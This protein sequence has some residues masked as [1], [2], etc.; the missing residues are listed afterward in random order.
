MGL[1]AALIGGITGTSLH[2]FANAT[3]KVPLS[4]RKYSYPHEALALAT[5]TGPA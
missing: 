1:G 2:M 4:R 5:S 3:K